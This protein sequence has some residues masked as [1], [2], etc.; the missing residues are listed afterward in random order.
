MET[1]LIYMSSLQEE[2]T[3]HPLEMKVEDE[4]NL[5][6]PKRVST[7]KI[8]LLNH[9]SEL[10]KSIYLTPPSYLRDEKQ[11]LGLV[12]GLQVIWGGGN[13]KGCYIMLP[14]DR[15]VL[16][17]KERGVAYFLLYYP[18]RASGSIKLPL[19]IY[20]NNV[21]V[22]TF[23]VDI[24][25]HADVRGFIYRPRYCPRLNN[26]MLEFVKKILRDQG[27]PDVEIYV[28]KTLFMPK[29]QIILDGVEIA[30]I[31]GDVG[32]GFRHF[33]KIR[34]HRDIFIGYAPDPITKDKRWYWV[35][36][37]WFFWLDKSIFDEVPDAE[38]VELWINP[39]TNKVDWLVTDKH[40]REV[41]Y[42][43]PVDN[44]KVKIEG[45]S[46]TYM[47]LRSYHPPVVTNMPRVC[48]SEDSRDPRVSARTIYI[49]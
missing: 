40:W 5:T 3:D 30:T 20:V 14:G 49:T 10:L 18:Y 11:V 42:R 47:P 32:S 43:G 9:S 39:D 13:P 16:K 25:L 34:L 12:K 48:V 45:G 37:V 28:W 15:D 7:L 38:R 46:R 6:F 4:S 22:G 26:G 19:E 24:T 35:V 2:S 1:R 17:P 8:S 31:V 44:A 27:I 21:Y 41:A 29:V 23:N 33:S 36:R